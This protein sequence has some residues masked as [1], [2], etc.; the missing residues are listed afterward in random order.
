MTAVIIEDE[1]LAVLELKQILKELAPDIQV[2]AVLSSVE[3]SMDWFAQNRADIIFSDIHLGDGQ[4]FDIFS[5]MEIKAP[6]VFITAYDE[7]A[8]K[9]FKHKGIAYILKPFDREEIAV[10]LANVKNWFGSGQALVQRRD[11]RPR[12][13]WLVH[14]G[15]KMKSVPVGEIAYFMA[16][17]KYLMLYTHDGMG[18]VVDQ[19]IGGIESQLDAVAFFRINRKFIISFKAIKDM[20]RYSNSRVRVVLVPSPPQHIEAIVSAERMRDFKEW[21]NR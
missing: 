10:T 17:G 13:R 4:S 12:E 14:V 3:E 6:V 19:T 11:V 15:N 1:M 8:L 7:Y 16:D 18:Y 20:I 9:A 2:M 5:R 21:L